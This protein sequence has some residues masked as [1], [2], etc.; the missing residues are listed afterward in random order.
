MG[1]ERVHATEDQAR[2]LAESSREAT[3]AG[4]SFV[5]EL[6]LGKFRFDW[7][8]P[9]PEQRDRPEFRAFYDKLDTWL[10]ETYDDRL[11]DRT[12]EIPEPWIDALAEM[13]A[14]GMKI[15][16]EYGGLGLNQYEY[17]LCLERLGEEDGNLVALL[18]AHQSIGV[19]TPVKLFG[20]KE[21]KERFLPRC[22]RGEVTA[23]ALTEPDVGSDPARLA[24]TLT[25]SEDGSHYIM[26]GE[27]LWIT[28]GTIAACCGKWVE[29]VLPLPP[30][31]QS[32]VVR[33]PIRCSGID[34]VLKAIRE[35]IAV[36]IR[37]RT[38]F[39]DSK[40]DGR[41]G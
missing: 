5:K 13:G 36:Q 29:S 17:G 37:S 2:E 41:H 18:S 34:E 4:R 31:W 30:V 35:A 23:F 26:S 39:L 14:F 11:V 33:I 25:L 24:T 3:W 21:Q 27:K 1:N 10:T 8:D 20:T 15:P 38:D 32:I 9:F 19:P 40:V 16:T 28:N 12:G 6:F 22:A 7:I